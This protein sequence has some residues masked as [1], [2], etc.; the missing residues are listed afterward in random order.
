M[1]RL[2]CLFGLHRYL[3]F[4]GSAMDLSVFYRCSRCQKTALLRNRLYTKGIL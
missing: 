1:K 2:L 3:W 4:K